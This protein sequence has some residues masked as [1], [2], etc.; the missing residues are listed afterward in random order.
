MKPK[1]GDSVR[2]KKLQKKGLVAEILPSGK[3]KILI[4]SMQLQCTEDE[5]TLLDEPPKKGRKKAGVAQKPYGSAPSTIDLHGVRVHEVQELLERAVNSAV[6]QQ[7]SELHV[8][9]GHGS[10]KVMRETHRVLKELSVVKGYKLH[11]VNR[12]TTRVFF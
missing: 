5:L 10:G 8:I 7:R 4:G 11:E 12:G 1:Q 9:H 2:V 6:L 3:Y